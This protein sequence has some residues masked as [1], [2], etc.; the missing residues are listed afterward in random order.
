[1]TETISVRIQKQE[2][3]EIEN[4][5][6]YEKTSKSNVL[7]EVLEKG[8]KE[9]KLGIAIEK[10][11][12]NEATASKASKIAGIPLTLFLDV[13]QRKGVNFHY[14]LNELREDLADLA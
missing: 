13:L 1:M 8:I 12:N 2:L 3:K 9:K 10:F 11:Q 14:D 6:S 5:S 7:R 4:I